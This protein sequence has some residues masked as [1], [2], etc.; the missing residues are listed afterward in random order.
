MAQTSIQPN[1]K[2]SA[3]IKIEIF[4]SPDCHRCTQAKAQLQQLIEE[5]GPER[6]EYR[7][8][9][10]VEEIDYA[11]KMRVLN[12]SAIAINGKLT[13]AISPNA[14]ALRHTLLSCLAEFTRNTVSNSIT[15]R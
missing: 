2:T 6:F 10:I 13:F 3:R 7:E 12:A 1:L 4:T 9:N 14:Q 8:V 15:K 11:V 5:L